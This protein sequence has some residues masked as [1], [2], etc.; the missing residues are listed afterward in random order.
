MAVISIERIVVMLIWMFSVA[1]IV[2]FVPVR[3]RREFAFAFLMCQTQTWLITL[4]HVK[5]G[6]LDFPVREFQY[7][8]DLLLATE[9]VYYPVLCAF[10]VIFELKKGGIPVLIGWTALAVSFLTVQDVLLE[11]YTNLLSYT[12]YDWYWTWLVFFVEFIIVRQLSRWFFR[13]RAGERSSR[14]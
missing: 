12:N 10:T 11:S 7:A 2:V 14:T 8:T 5:Y 13:I 6:L 3:K 1:A 4:V 9:Y